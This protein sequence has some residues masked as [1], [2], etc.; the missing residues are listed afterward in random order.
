MY[1]EA[2]EA[3]EGKEKG[4]ILMEN[5]LYIS[6]NSPAK[7][8]LDGFP[9]LYLILEVVATCVNLLEDKPLFVKNEYQK[10]E[11][12]YWKHNQKVFKLIS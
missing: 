7:V 3:L 8:R 4:N 6:Q 12:Q 1:D 9:L 11:M 10:G 2:Y 5:L